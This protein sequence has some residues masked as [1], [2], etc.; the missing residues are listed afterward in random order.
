MEIKIL[1]Q[2]FISGAEAV[3]RYKETKHAKASRASRAVT[4]IQY[5]FRLGTN[6]HQHAQSIS[7]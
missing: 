7:Y 3:K 4:I 6:M 2:N 1:K 5:L